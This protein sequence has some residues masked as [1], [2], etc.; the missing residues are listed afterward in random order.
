MPE[1]K[2]TG[3]ILFVLLRLAF[4]ICLFLSQLASPRE[5]L[6]TQNP[7]L[8]ALG[9]LF[10]LAGVLLWISAG[11]HLNQ[12]QLA[13]EFATGGPFKYVRHPVYISMYV[14][15]VGLGFLFFTPLWFLVLAAFLPLWYL[16]CR[17]E[18]REMIEI[19]GEKYVE[20]QEQTRM[21][22]PKFS[23]SL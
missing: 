6:F 17:G 11:R 1:E 10:V 13:G 14:L 12:A 9:L 4:A 7:Y 23:R 18:E 19:Y 5:T 16:E 20:Y 15:S 8:L 3:K 2:K 21:L 22:V